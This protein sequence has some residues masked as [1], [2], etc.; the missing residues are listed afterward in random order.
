MRL[1]YP[2]LLYVVKTGEGDVETIF[3]A[4]RSPQAVMENAQEKRIEVVTY[5]RVSEPVLYDTVVGPVE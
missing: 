2:E 3:Y 4:D 5:R 1:K